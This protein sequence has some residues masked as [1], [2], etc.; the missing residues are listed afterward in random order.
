VGAEVEVLIVHRP[1]YDDWSLP[2]GKLDAADSSEVACA[3]REVFEETGYEVDVGPEA[4]STSYV[5]RAG[6]DKRV[7]YWSMT[8]RCGTFQANSEVDAVAWVGERDLHRLTYPHDREM[9]QVVIAARR[10]GRGVH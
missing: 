6:R 7:R 5:D 1:R 3:V 8:V 2:K 4:G 10:A 9:A